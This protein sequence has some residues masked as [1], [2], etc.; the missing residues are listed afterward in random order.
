M[1]HGE[2]V[3]YLDIHPKKEKVWC[4]IGDEGELE[5]IDW[6]IVEGLAASF[7]STQPEHRTESMLIAKLM[8]LVRKETRKE[9]G[10]DDRQC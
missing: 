3:S 8:Y 7:D 10:N 5:Y 1:E 4:K 9:I 6:E 2:D